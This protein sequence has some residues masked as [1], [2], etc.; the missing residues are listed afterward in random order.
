[1][2]SNNNPTPISF[3]NLDMLQRFEEDQRAIHAKYQPFSFTLPSGVAFPPPIESILAHVGT[4]PGHHGL[5]A[6]GPGDTKSRASLASPAVVTQAAYPPPSTTAASAH[7][8]SSIH[9]SSLNLMSGID[10]F[11]PLGDESLTASGPADDSAATV[12]VQA[13]S[14]PKELTEDQV[15]P[16]GNLC[17]F[18]RY[19]DCHRGS[20]R[21][22][23]GWSTLHTTTTRRADG[24]II[25][26]HY[27]LGCGKCPEP[28]CEFVTRILT[29]EQGRSRTAAA[30]LPTNAKCPNHPD[31]ELIYKDCAGH[32]TG[33][34]P[35]GRCRI[36]VI[37]RNTGSLEIHHYGT[38]DHDRP[39]LARPAP[40]AIAHLTKM[41]MIDPDN[42]P[43]KLQVGSPTNPGLPKIDPAFNN[44]SRVKHHRKKIKQEH[45]TDGIGK[46][47]GDLLQF[48]A[49]HPS[50]FKLVNLA[51]T[52]TCP[53]QIILM[54][55]K[56]MEQVMLKSPIGQQ[57][58]TIEGM[59][60]DGSFK[61][62]PIDLHF[63]SAYDPLLDRWVPVVMSVI[64][65]RDGNVYAENWKAV[66]NTYFDNGATTWDE[67]K[68]Q[69][70]GMT[71]DWS[72]AE[73]TSFLNSL[74]EFGKTKLKN[75]GLTMVDVQVFLRKCG[76]HF[77][78]SVDR[79]GTI[80]AVVPPSRK[81][82]FILLCMR[83]TRNDTTFP[84]GVQVVKQ[85]VREF[86]RCG[87][88]LEWHLK[89]DRAQSFFPCF[90]K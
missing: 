90:Q 58:D 49:E 85:L 54:M 3:R 51:C 63:V 66:F 19:E 28:G 32:I 14:G 30:R 46:G 80:S 67:F 59:V 24:S 89:P 15:W 22:P 55:D 25:R 33:N 68:D 16:N 84:Q 48:I 8:W 9:S 38:H 77:R 47:I 34:G 45:M 74:L 60:H 35:P 50:F 6:A 41:V 64:I 57:T 10:P 12:A 70:F 69:F 75:E 76:I 11:A 42:G 82:E 29:P 21:P 13:C 72:G 2:S 43:A 56:E 44:I 31:A 4:T 61:S 39:P 83:L 7:L 5:D 20:K 36:D 18:I 87:A 1:M 40:H 37:D 79:I 78:R 23:F 81:E 26:T 17:I 62:R 88:F 65:G 73:G 53:C 86:P 71:M 52:S 27:C